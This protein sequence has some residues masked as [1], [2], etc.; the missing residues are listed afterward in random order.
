MDS[1]KGDKFGMKIDAGLR[2]RAVGFGDVCKSLRM[3]P[4]VVLH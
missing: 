1:K 3:M 4:D 2:I